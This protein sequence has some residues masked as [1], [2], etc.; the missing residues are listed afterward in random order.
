M[1]KLL[2]ILEKK[3]PIEKNTKE[4]P[5]LIITLDGIIIN[6]ISTQVKAYLEKFTNLQEIS[7]VN[8]NLQNLNNFPKLPNLLKLDL[9][10]NHLKDDDLKELCKYKNL[11]ELRMANNNKIGD[12]TK[13]KVLE[14]LPLTFID[15]SDCP[16]SK[17]KNYRETFYEGFKSLKYLDL[18]DK[19]GKE[20]DEDDEEEEEADDE[21][22][23]FIDDDLKNENNNEEKENDDAEEQYEEED[24]EQYEEENEEDEIKNPHPAKKKKTE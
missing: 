3:F 1:S 2:T 19:N 14:S 4:N 20:W 10:D 11:T 9:S 13:I 15:F 12:F 21:D 7:M 18:A 16:I 6:E 8:C 17:M 22:N 23:Q 5:T 24:N